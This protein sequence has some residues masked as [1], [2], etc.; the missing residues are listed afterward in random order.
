MSSRIRCG[1]LMESSGPKA[2]SALPWA[3]EDGNSFF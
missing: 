3:D 1:A 2:Y